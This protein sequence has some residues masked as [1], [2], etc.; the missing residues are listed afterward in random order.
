MLPALQRSVLELDE[1]AEAI[2]RSSSTPGKV[3]LIKNLCKI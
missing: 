2:N 3:D 1:L